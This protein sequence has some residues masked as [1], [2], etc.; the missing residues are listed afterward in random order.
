MKT[1]DW[2]VLPGAIKSGNNLVMK[3]FAWRVQ[4]ADGWNECVT[5]YIICPR[6]PTQK[7]YYQAGFKTSSHGRLCKYIRE[8]SGWTEFCPK[9][10]R[11]YPYGNDDSFSGAASR[12]WASGTN[13][14]AEW[15]TD[16]P[17]PSFAHVIPDDSAKLGWYGKMIHGLGSCFGGCGSV[18]GCVCC[19]NPYHRGNPA[20]QPGCN[21][22]VYEGQTG[23]VLKFGRYSRAVDPGLTRVNP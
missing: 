16:F 17:K 2:R 8:T 7:P 18:P 12:D 14:K 11:L 13:Q 10:R 20:S 22:V 5:L 4:L 1:R 23:L 6:A 19:P 3:Q 15:K 21:D 9:S